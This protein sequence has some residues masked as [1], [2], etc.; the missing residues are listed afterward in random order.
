MIVPWLAGQVQA[1]FI[2]VQAWWEHCG[3]ADVVVHLASST[4]PATAN[5]DPVVDALRPI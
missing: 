5:A 1:E 2:S 3:G 4:V